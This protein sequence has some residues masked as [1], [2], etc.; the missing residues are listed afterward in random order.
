MCV[1][2]MDKRKILTY[3]LWLYGLS[4]GISAL[5]F[6]SGLGGNPILLFLFMTGYMLIPLITVLIVQKLIYK[7]AVARPLLLTGRPNWWW[8]FAMVLPLLFIGLTA[9]VASLF[10]G[11]TLD[12]GMENYISTVDATTSATM[13]DLFQKLP[14]HPLWLLAGQ[15]LIGGITI[16]AILGFGEEI[17]WR[18]FLLREFRALGFWKASLL[19]GFIWGLWH[20]PL[21]IFAGHNYPSTPILGVLM[22]TVSCMLISPILSLLTIKSRSVFPAAF[23]HGV[24]N[25]SA[26]LGIMIVSGGNPEL[27]TGFNG[28]AGFIVLLAV[29]VIIFIRTRRTI[30]D[31]YKAVFAQ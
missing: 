22:M 28:L 1:F 4:F 24:I 30:N 17:G 26:S 10:P 23:F 31:R 27:L 13:N 14:F 20:V 8:P 15:S 16:N 18:G 21:T 6:L 7:E 12:L 3:V 2:R 9:L 25:G 11:V 29:N 19:I 5:F